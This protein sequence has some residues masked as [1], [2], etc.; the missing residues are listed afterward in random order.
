MGFRF[1]IFPRLFHEGVLAAFLGDGS[2]APYWPV[3]Q[4][5]MQ[6]TGFVEGAD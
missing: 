1:L 6:Y 5:M 2:E 4:E 3:L